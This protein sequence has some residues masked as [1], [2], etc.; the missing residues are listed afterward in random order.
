VA[1]SLLRRY[2]AGAF[3]PIRSDTKVLGVLG[4][5]FR[6]STRPPAGQLRFLDALGR[7]LGTAMHVVG[8][9]ESRRETRSETRF[10]RRIAAALSANLEL[11]RSSTW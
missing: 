6:E 7:Q 8:A 5:G 4:V 2:G 1:R 11:L 10:L 9:G 3:I